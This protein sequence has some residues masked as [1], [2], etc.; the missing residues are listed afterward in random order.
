MLKPKRAI[1]MQPGGHRIGSTKSKEIRRVVLVLAVCFLAWQAFSAGTAP[2]LPDPGNPRMGRDQ[3][4][5]LG[6]QVAA[7]VYQQMPVL[8]D[9]S[10]Q[11]KYIQSLGRR[12]AATIPPKHSWPFQFHVIQQKEINA[13]ALPGGPMFVN[14][15]TIV[16]AETEAQLAGVMAHEMGHVYMQH[17]AKQQD[18]ASLL[19]G[20]AGIAGA[21]AGNIGGNWGT[22]AQSGIQIGAGTLMLKYSRGDEAQADSVGA[23]ILWKAGFNPLALADFFRKI[24]AQ[25]GSGPQFLSDHPNPGNR[26]QAIKTE[27]RDWPPRDYSGNSPQFAAARKDAPGVPAY[28]AQEIAAGAK[29]GRWAA[30]NRKNGAVLPGAAGAQAAAAGANSAIA[31]VPRAPLTSLQP[32]SNF[33]AEAIG[34]VTIERPDNWDVIQNQQSRSATIAPSAGISGDVVAYGVVIQSVS[35][36]DAGMSAEQLASAAAKNLQANDPNMKQNGETQTIRLDGA[37]AGS[38]RLTT[39]SPMPGPDGK[40]QPERDWLVAVPRGGTRAVFLVFVAPEAHFDV[41]KP[42]FEK[43]LGSVRF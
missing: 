17:S 27:I 3:Q 15:G 7:Q 26:E 32:S 16:A 6:L 24:E 28:T 41:M 1:A 34:E 19:G 11:T 36:T 12:L 18:K 30:E 29:N 37:P 9:S 13:F 5:K 40:P 25:G 8:P 35:T 33:R 21:I 20:L 22:L 23:I 14:V 10:P 4:E 39:L 43:M 2:T 38:A 31:A 42:T